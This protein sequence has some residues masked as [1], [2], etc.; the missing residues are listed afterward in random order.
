MRTV[1]ITALILNLNFSSA[2]QLLNDTSSRYND[3]YSLGAGVHYGF[4][5]AHVKEVE[6]TKG[7]LPWGIEIDLSRQLINNPVWDECRCYPRTGLVVSYFDLDNSVLGKSI[8]AAWYV[9]PFLSVHHRINLSMK[10]AAGLSYLT[11]PY[12]EISNPGNMS[13]STHLSFY[14]AMGLGLNLELNDHFSAKLSAYYNHSSNGAVKEPNKGINLPVSTLHIYYALNPSLFPERQKNHGSGYRKKPVRKE[15]LLLAT[16]RSL[17]YNENVHYLIIGAGFNASKQLSGMHAL[18]LGIEG[19]ADYS[20][21]KR[22]QQDNKSEKSFFQ[23]GIL[24]GHE[25]LM[26]K[27][28]FSQQLGVYVFK[29]IPYY[30]DVYQRYGLTYFFHKSFGAG[31]SLKAHRHVANFLDGRIVYRF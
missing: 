26:G 5:F 6:N 20:V 3:I 25:F 23:A 24:I 15:V 13:Y 31:I 28:I 21:R 9:E 2:Q 30:D 8:N 1:F 29:Q 19:I 16:Q 10:G 11:N 4:I 22:L 7:S 14:L 17:L 12:N 18:S 27:F